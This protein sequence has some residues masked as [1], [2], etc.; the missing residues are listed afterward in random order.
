M[1]KHWYWLVGLVLLLALLL[2]LPLLSGSFWL[3]EAAQALESARPLSQQLNIRDDFQPPLLH[4]IVHFAQYGSRAEWWQR[5]FG[6]VLPGIFSI[7]GTMLIA[8][9]ILS[10]NF[11][12]NGSLLVGILLATNS[13]HIFFSQELRPYALPMLF[14]VWSWWVLLQA[15]H[16]PK[17]VVSWAVLSLLGLYS[18]YLY[19]FLLLSQCIYLGGRIWKTK[20]VQIWLAG[21]LGIILGFIPWLPSFVSQLQ[22]GQLLRI[23]LPQWETT[24]ST[25]QLKVLP[26]VL[27]KFIYGVLD[28]SVNAYYL[29]GVTLLCLLIGILTLGL[30]KNQQSKPISSK[31][32][33]AM[34]LLVSWLFVPLL[35]AWLVSFFVPV[36]Q[37]KRVIFLLPAF[38]LLVVW[39]FARSQ[40]MSF[41]YH[42]AGCALVGILICIN[43][44]S[45]HQ[46]YTDQRLQ[47]ENWRDVLATVSRKHPQAFTLS[48]FPAPF[49]PIEWYRPAFINSPMAQDLASG[50]LHI[51]SQATADQIIDDIALL[52]LTNTMIYFEYLTDLTDP[53]QYLRTAIEN[54]GYQLQDLLDYPGIGFVR[55]YQ[56]TPSYALR[57]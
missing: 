17:Y 5:L 51:D 53:N 46:Y 19:P 1:E 43:L 49:A 34:S 23:Q 8:R 56:Y 18:S 22:A 30:L 11:S 38:Y 25:S 39:A 3:D 57:N 7:L 12:S 21:L 4:L 29:G 50:T 40:S 47:R 2:R 20:S 35:S 41:W 36:I 48:S 32:K 24:V 16:S 55:I 42:R 9:K 33:Q 27:A 14:A 44:F 37:P 28:V 13:F 15:K 52:K 31:Q 6:A 45:V 54:S 26:L 10:K